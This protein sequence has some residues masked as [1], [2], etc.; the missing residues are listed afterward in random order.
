MSNA[1][2]PFP[3]KPAAFALPSKAVEYGSGVIVSADGHI[4]TSA[5][6]AESCSMVSVA[7]VGPAELVSASDG[8]V[9]LRG[10]QADADRTVNF[11]GR[12]AAQFDWRTRSAG[13][14]GRLSYPRAVGE[15]FRSGDR[16]CQTRSRRGLF[17]RCRDR[18][19]RPSRGS[20]RSEQRGRRQ[21]RRPAA[22]DDRSRHDP[23]VSRAR[24]FRTLRGKRHRASGGRARD[25]RQE[26]RTLSSQ[27]SEARPGTHTPQQN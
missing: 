22:A 11:G 7:G 18:W 1:F 9:L 10:A 27:A 15:A 17:G 16:A 13:A 2:A 23:R 5:R 24:G 26:V 6:I 19:R 20:C 3:E 14:A 4:V 25:L 12:R 8:M 21:H